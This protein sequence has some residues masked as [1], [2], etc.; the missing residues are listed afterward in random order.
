MD[1][2]VPNRTLDR[3]ITM[4]SKVTMTVDL[5]PEVQAFIDEVKQAARTETGG[6]TIAKVSKLFTDAM[7]LA[8]YEVEK[9]VVLAGTQKKQVVI[10][11]ISQVYDIVT[12]YIPWPAFIAPFTIL[13]KR[14]IKATVL[15]ICDGAIESIVSRLPQPPVSNVKLAA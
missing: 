13:F 7:H 12:P 11:T 9:N 5:G 1:R 6:L 10:D 14:Q 2:R 3:K 4:P 15:L 8:V